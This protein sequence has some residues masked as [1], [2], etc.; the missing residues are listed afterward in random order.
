MQGLFYGRPLPL[1]NKNTKLFKSNILLFDNGLIVKL[2]LHSNIHLN[3]VPAVIVPAG[4]IS[5]V[6]SDRTI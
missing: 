6:T 5:S 2:G 1:F 4:F 3:V